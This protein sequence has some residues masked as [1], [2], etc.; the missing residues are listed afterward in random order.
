MNFN[1]S[2]DELAKNLLDTYSGDDIISAVFDIFDFNCLEWCNIPTK[3][4]DKKICEFKQSN[5]KSSAILA[6]I[7]D[8]IRK[9]KI[10]EEN[11]LLNKATE[12]IDRHIFDAF[13]IEDIAAEIPISSFYLSHL[14][15]KHKKISVGEYRTNKRLKK[16]FRLLLETD[17]KITDI[18]FQCGFN[19]SSYFTET[20]TQKIGFSPS[21]IRKNKEDI[22]IHDFYELEDM[23]SALYY[24]PVRFIKS[25][26]RE[27]AYSVRTEFVKYPD[28]EYRFLHECA[29]ISF[30][31]RLF[32]S[33]YQCPVNELQGH[34]PIVGKRSSDGGNTW[35][36]IEVIAEDKTD[37]ILY[38]PPVYGVDNGKLYMFVNQMVAP[39]H[40]HSL[41]LYVLNEASDR[42]EHLWSRPIPFKLNTNVIR[43]ENGK[44]MLA[45]RV[46]E[47]DGFPNTPAVMISDNGKIDD[48]WRLVKVA[49]DGNL[50]DGTKFVHPEISPISINESIY[51][52][53]RN[54]QR[55]VPIVYC[56]HDF[57]EHF[58]E[59]KALDIPMWKTKVYCGTL[60][61]GRNYIICNADRNNRSKLVL[62]LTKP[63]SIEVA[64][65]Q[66]LYDAMQTADT[67]TCHYPCA[68]E[69]DNMLHIIATVDICN[70]GRGAVLLSVDLK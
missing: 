70:K 2:N 4:F 53:C 34:T 18:A 13:T 32:T 39:D 8:F 28:E 67:V 14:F 37:K 22:I 23:I 69:S 31:G 48:E 15:K 27:S 36:N 26:P 59:A 44:L 6:E 21:Y 5:C 7:I 16:A 62:Y 61:D 55:A 54:D 68:Y 17:E 64:E 11:Q 50:S 29:I 19:S 43:L 9:G 41:D 35:S 66:T 12:H 42:F 25:T 1:R 3:E 56:S 46:G 24:K 40:I 65:K 33:W 45:G 47:P 51:M 30:N 63:N 58:G 57:G 60:T 38:C 52:L 10:T 20:F 49:E